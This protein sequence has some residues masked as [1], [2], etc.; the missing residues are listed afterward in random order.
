MK[1]TF[2]CS[3]A[4]FCLDYSQAIKKLNFSLSMT[5]NKQY[6][7]TRVCCLGDFRSF[8]DCPGCDRYL[9]TTELIRHSNRL[10]SCTAVALIIFKYPRCQ[11]NSEICP[12]NNIFLFSIYLFSISG[13]FNRFPPPNIFHSLFHFR[14][15]V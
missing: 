12:V 3:K 4:V 9:P 15:V 11:M 1:G 13:S 8:A 2:F 6:N 7:W 10:H 14:I 5:N